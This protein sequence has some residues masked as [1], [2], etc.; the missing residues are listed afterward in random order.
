MHRLYAQSYVRTFN[1]E[2][3]DGRLQRTAFFGTRHWILRLGTLNHRYRLLS[4]TL[5]RQESQTR[6]ATM[7]SKGL[8]GRV[9]D[10][11]A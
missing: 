4:Y 11:E 10:V 1:Q 2:N 3:S 9:A 5:E 8:P 6:Y 7:G